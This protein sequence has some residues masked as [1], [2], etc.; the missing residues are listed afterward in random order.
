M[1]SHMIP[2]RLVSS[3]SVYQ[4]LYAASQLQ[5]SELLKNRPVLSMKKKNECAL[6]VGNGAGGI[7][8][9]TDFQMKDSG[10]RLV[11]SR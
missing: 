3:T 10:H 6:A 1:A 5:R 11:K 8:M 9:T 4:V 7:L 2:V